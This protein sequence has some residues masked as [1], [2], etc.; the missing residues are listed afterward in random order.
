M[1]LSVQQPGSS[2]PYEDGSFRVARWQL[3]DFE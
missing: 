2:E 1:R 3:A